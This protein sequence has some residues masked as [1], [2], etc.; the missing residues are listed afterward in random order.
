MK[1]TCNHILSPY[2]YSLYEPKSHALMDYNGGL[3]KA[4]L[5]DSEFLG[6]VMMPFVIASSKGCYKI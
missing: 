1:I 6:D 3:E 5:R 4:I 2:S